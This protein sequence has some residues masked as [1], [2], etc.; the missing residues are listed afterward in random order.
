MSFAVRSCSGAHLPGLTCP[1]SAVGGGFSPLCGHSGTVVT[2]EDDGQGTADHSWTT[3]GT[4]RCFLVSAV[5]VCPGRASSAAEQM[6]MRM[7]SVQSVNPDA[8][9]GS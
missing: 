9:L 8:I 1:T 2:P 5:D 3:L 6:I 7:K 4:S